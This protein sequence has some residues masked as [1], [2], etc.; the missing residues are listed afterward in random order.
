MDY[1]KYSSR[2]SGNLEARFNTLTQ[3]PTNKHTYRF[4][5]VLAIEL[6]SH[7]RIA[8]DDNND[9]HDYDDA[10]KNAGRVAERYNTRFAATP[11]I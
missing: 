9:D 6:S 10:F 4:G 1:R 3:N 5:K 8:E 11:F 2:Y 7:M